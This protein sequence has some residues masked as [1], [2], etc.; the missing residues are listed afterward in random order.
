MSGVCIYDELVG[1]STL[2]KNTGL[3]KGKSYDRK[4]DQEILGQQPCRNFSKQKKNLVSLMSYKYSFFEREETFHLF[5]FF[6]L[7]SFLF[8]FSLAQKS[9]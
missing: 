4:K 8:S 7:S 1:G 9:H 3:F 2:G 6:F 5:F